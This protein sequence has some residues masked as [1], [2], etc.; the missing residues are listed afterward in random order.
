MYVT[1]NP[2][3]GPT[4]ATGGFRSQIFQGWKI[5]RRILSG[6]PSSPAGVANA[7]RFGSGTRQVCF[8]WNAD[9][10]EK[11]LQ[12]CSKVPVALL[13]GQPWN[14]RTLPGKIRRESNYYLP[15]A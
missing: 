8:G 6:F 11:P 4:G 14:D 5:V 1:R 7:V 9:K 10:S 2:A 3:L 12:L 15:A 13:N